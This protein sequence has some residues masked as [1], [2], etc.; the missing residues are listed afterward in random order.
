M[1]P[2]R[3]YS[4]PT[5]DEGNTIAEKH[6]AHSE[7][8]VAPLADEIEAELPAIAPWAG[9][10]AFAPG[11]RRYARAAAVAEL[12][13]RYVAEHGP[14][15]DDGKPRPALDALAKW[16]SIAANR[17]AALALDPASFA[18]LIGALTLASGPEAESMVDALAAEGRRILD[19]RSP[20]ALGEPAEMP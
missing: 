12:L 18:K 10:D 5:A 6:G 13:W 15:D 1:S 9:R 16:E 2:G 20:A 19:A 17:G 4:W 3:G 8:K 11:R 7:R 14:L